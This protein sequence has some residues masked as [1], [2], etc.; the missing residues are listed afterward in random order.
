MLL[1]VPLRGVNNLNVC[2]RVCACVITAALSRQKNPYQH[3]VLSIRPN[4]GKGQTIVMYSIS[5]QWVGPLHFCKCFRY[6]F[7]VGQHRRNDAAYSFWSSV[8]CVC[9]KWVMMH[10]IHVC[11]LMCMW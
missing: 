6:I 3:I 11:M 9:G 5:R 8:A 2:V 10:R 7:F 1:A 4:T